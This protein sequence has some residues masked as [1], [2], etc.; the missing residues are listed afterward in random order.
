ML[1]N[2]YSDA[3]DPY[4]IVQESTLTRTKPMW[5]RIPLRTFL[6]EPFQCMLSKLLCCLYVWLWFTVWSLL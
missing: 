2:T 4:E 6:V 1:C 3:M 5:N